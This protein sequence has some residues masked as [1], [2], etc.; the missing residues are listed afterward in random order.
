MST[1]FSNAQGTTVGD[2]ANFPTVFGNFTTNHY[3]NSGRDDRVTLHGRTVRRIIEGDIN[4][5]RI[6]SSEILS[7]NVKPKG[8]SISTG[9]QVVKLKRMEQT[10]TIYG[11]RG[12][13]TATS[14]EPV[15]EKDRENF[16]EIMKAVLE[17][18]M[19][20]KSALLKQVFAVVESNVM[21]LIAHDGRFFVGNSDCGYSE[22]TELANGFEIT[23]RYWRKEWIV[24]YYLDYTLNTAVQF[25]R[26]DETVAN[27]WDG[28]SF[29][30]QTLSWQYDPA[31]LC[32]NPPNKRS[33]EPLFYLPPRLR[34]ENLPHLNIAEI[35]AFFE[36][37]FGDVLHLIA[38][39]G[40][41]R[42]TDL[43][44]YARHG[45]L[46]FGAVVD[47]NKPGF[48]AHLPSIPPPEWFCYSRTP[49]VKAN[50]SSSG[51]VD[52]LFQKTGD[53]DVGLFFG[54]RI[55]ENERNRLGSAFLCQSFGFCDDSEDVTD[56]VYIDQLGFSLEGT[57]PHDPTS[58][59]TPA[60]LFLR[61]LHTELINNLHCVRY[62]FPKNLFYWSHD[63]QGRNTI[64][65]EDWKRYGIPELSMKEWIGTCWEEEDYNT[66]QEHLDSRNFDLDGK[67]YARERGY[68][69]LIFGAQHS[70]R[71]MDNSLTF[72]LSTADPHGNDR[73][74]EYESSDCEEL[75]Y[76]DGEFET[77]PS[78][79]RLGS[80]STCSL[81]EAPAECTM[82][83]QED[84]PMLDITELAATT[85]IAN[86]RQKMD[87]GRASE[88]RYV[89]AEQHALRNKNHETSRGRTFKGSSVRI[90]CPLPRRN[91]Y[92]TEPGISFLDRF[93]SS[94]PHV[95]YSYG[96][97]ELTFHPYTPPDL[98]ST[99]MSVSMDGANKPASRLFSRTRHT[100]GIRPQFA[101]TDS[102]DLMAV[103][104]KN[105]RG[106][107][108]IIDSNSA[109]IPHPLS[110]PADPYYVYTTVVHPPAAVT[111]NSYYPP[112]VAGSSTIPQPAATNCDHVPLTT[113]NIFSS[114][115]SLVNHAPFHNMPAIGCPTD[116]LSGFAM[117]DGDILPVPY[118][119]VGQAETTASSSL[120]TGD[121]QSVGTE[122]LYETMADSTLAQRHLWG[123]PDAFDGDNTY[124][125][126]S[127]TNSVD[128]SGTSQ[129][130]TT[131]LHHVLST[132][133]CSSRYLLP[134]AHNYLANPSMAWDT[135]NPDGNVWFASDRGEGRAPEQYR[136]IASRFYQEQPTIYYPHTNSSGEEYQ[137]PPSAFTAWNQ[138]SG[139]ERRG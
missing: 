120:H 95:N 50:F 38:S 47:R 137:G 54:W 105:A 32:L 52:L 77:S 110:N 51:R 49:D 23:S 64:A 124:A 96:H 62:P 24:Y 36:E 7:V 4:F 128:L 63:P 17:A 94:S 44:H 68:P 101:T 98:S 106:G 138:Y 56:I 55:P 42:I 18:A 116:R 132:T 19:R 31:S 92:T 53:V 88:P 81:V 1:Y 121:T 82:G 119:G 30:L 79:S 97:R 100:V 118:S 123:S 43:S 114:A 99:D 111:S 91:V 21:T 35:S 66:V 129:L 25:L 41:S 45:L 37:G 83:Q 85:H 14:F 65:E 75:E 57:F 104:Q 12:K 46:T 27:R 115:Q 69:E 67:Q 93:S 107:R 87:A 15:A 71:D 29:N 90:I 16:N 72:F 86:K 74:E 112:S 127:L 11:Y 59:S 117:P 126:P 89:Y 34:Q 5:Q 102:V 136:N 8:E 10:A 70:L 122:L 139:D 108:T 134:S 48:L 80:P 135:Y 40:G 84:T 125:S 22:A 131:N 13:F 103:S 61:P 60:Y 58:R 133:A 113:D 73:I 9:S 109:F 20:G 26:N 6:L 2:Y 33:L 28:W 39:Y 130:A 76:S 78:H 3:H